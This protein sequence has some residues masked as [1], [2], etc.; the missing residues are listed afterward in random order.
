MQKTKEIFD[1]SNWSID[2]MLSS[3]EPLVLRNV[4]AG[5]PLVQHGS[6][7]TLLNRLSNTIGS[8][9]MFAMSGFYEDRG[10]I[11]YSDAELQSSTRNTL[12]GHCPF[13]KFA[14][15]LLGMSHGNQ[16]GYLYCQ[17]PNL[18]ETAPELVPLIDHLGAQ[19]RLS[20]KQATWNMWLGSGNHRVNTHYDKVENFY[21]VLQGK[22][23][24]Q[25]FP[26]N[27][28]PNL[29]SGP[30]EGG[31]SGIP[32]SVVDS[33]DPDFEKFPRF[34]KALQA[35][36]TA[37]LCA[38]DMLYLPTN[39]W[40][41]VRSEGLNISVNLWWSDIREAERL[42]AELAFL[43][44]LS[45]I[46]TLPQHWKDYWEVNVGHYVFG[47]NG[48]PFHHLPRERQGIA[49]EPGTDVLTEIRKRML[50][51]E[52]RVSRLELNIDLSDSRLRLR[53]SDGLNFTL[54]SADQIEIRLGA[55]KILT[56]RYDALELL[57]AFAEP[58]RPLDA[59]KA[60]VA[61]A[62]DIDAF[63]RKLVEFVRSGIIAISY[64]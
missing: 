52:Q 39:W 2:Q 47:R 63:A 42:R 60:K 25:L 58:S 51:I 46:K 35:S 9:I 56:D 33:S 19:L 15:Q 20:G 11:G 4:N 55:K 3:R 32:E 13:E 48:D 22:K 21:F 16:P 6:E 7:T 36:Q 49:G 14:N 28:L 34:A 44:L 50:D 40:H 1:L 10:L 12:T 17:L 24:F 64:A 30:Y 26:P 61:Q 53:C 54:G 5:S 23:I 59:Y 27:S 57:G 37:E 62:Y 45:S 29:Y 31:P 43:H 18:D 8:R 41:N 38:G